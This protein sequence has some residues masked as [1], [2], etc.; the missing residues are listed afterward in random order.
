M[1]T[2]FHS[3]NPGFD[4]EVAEKILN[5]IYYLMA[6]PKGE[7]RNISEF[8]ILTVVVELLL[9]HFFRK[10]QSLKIYTISGKLLLSNIKSI[11]FDRNFPVNTSDVMHSI[12]RLT[13]LK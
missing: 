10:L 4:A 3:I 12:N 8:H 7:M 11:V 13:R 5:G 1:L 9:K 2:Y 6:G